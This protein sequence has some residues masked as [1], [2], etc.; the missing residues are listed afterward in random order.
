M[1]ILHLHFS[2]L[3]LCGAAECFTDKLVD[4]GQNVTLNCDISTKDVYWFLMKPSQPP[5]YI[6]R[7]FAKASTVPVYSN[8]S[9]SKRFSL[10]IN[11]SLVIHNITL[12]ELGI[13]YCMY[14]DT[15]PKI[16]TGIRILHTNESCSDHHKTEEHQQLRNHTEGHKE[17]TRH[18]QTPLIISGL[19]N[20]VLLFGVIGLTVQCCKRPKLQPQPQESNVQRHQDLNVQYEEIELPTSTSG[21]RQSQA[22]STYALLQFPK[23]RQG[24]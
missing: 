7:S 13:Y 18:Q 9:F 14:N 24:A 20:C 23:P 21:V 12:N 1:K 15:P 2:L 3:L 10:Q 5:L 16:S 8:S 11:S 4:L 17:V 22:N 6:L 19:M